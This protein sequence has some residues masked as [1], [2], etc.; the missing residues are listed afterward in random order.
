VLERLGKHGERSHFCGMSTLDGADYAPRVLAV[1][2][3][4]PGAAAA[5]VRAAP[6]V[7]GGKREMGVI[8]WARAPEGW[9]GELAAI[10]CP[11][12]AL[13]MAPDLVGLRVDIQHLAPGLEA[14]DGDGLAIVDRGAAA[15]EFDS[16]KFYAWDVAGEVHIGWLQGKP[17]AGEATCLGRVVC[18]I[19]EEDKARA[20]ARSCWK[21]E[22]ELY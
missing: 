4:V 20:R 9:A 2:G 7:A 6:A 17:T 19:L 16:L 15:R 18:V 3:R 11:T 8:A 21:E 13:G 12:D 14:S 1:A 22:D 10:D 5:D